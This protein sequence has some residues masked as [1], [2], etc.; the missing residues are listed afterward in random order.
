MIDGV[1][2]SDS[3]EWEIGEQAIK[4]LEKPSVNDA[5]KTSSARNKHAP[6][7]YQQATPY[8]K[9]LIPR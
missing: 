3:K 6:L 9:L 4:L 1:I 7:Q 8:N 2:F 5:G